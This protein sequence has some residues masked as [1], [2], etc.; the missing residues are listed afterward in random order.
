MAPER[1]L[2]QLEFMRKPI[3]FKI[4][5]SNQSNESMHI[6]ESLQEVQADVSEEYPVLCGT[7]C[8][9]FMVV[10][11]EYEEGGF[12]KMKKEKQRINATQHTHIVSWKQQSVERKPW[13]MN[14]NT[15]CFRLSEIIEL[16]GYDTSSENYLKEDWDLEMRILEKYRYVFNIQEP[17]LLYRI[18]PNQETQKLKK[19]I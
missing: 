10:D 15:L 4:N 16:G 14:G 11:K 19:Q 12:K 6:Q 1:M 5:E 13:F 2:K 8:I 18:H 17:L 3:D 9:L 7:Q